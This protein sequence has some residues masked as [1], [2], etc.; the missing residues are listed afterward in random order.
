MSN[1]NKT[2]PGVY[3]GALQTTTGPVF[4]AVPFNPDNV[5]RTTVGSATFA[6]TDANNGSFTYTV[7]GVTQSKPITRYIYASPT[8]VCQ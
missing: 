4:S 7:N 8:T 3:S 1:G 2:A 5:T 6:F